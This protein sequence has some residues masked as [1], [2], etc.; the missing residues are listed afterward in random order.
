[1]DYFRREQYLDLMGIKTWQSKNV[2]YGDV[3]TEIVESESLT[4]SGE[5]EVPANVLQQQDDSAASL[6]EA[7]K[8]SFISNSAEDNSL[9]VTT[10]IAQISPETGWSELSTLVSSCTKCELCKTRTNTVF[11][12]GSDVADLMVVAEAPGAEE[13]AQGIPFMGR[14]GKLLDNMLLAIGLNRQVVFVSNVLKCQ[15][16]ENRDPHPEEVVNCMP[17]LQQQIKLLKP[18][19]ILA[20]GTVAA[21]NLLNLQTP[22][23]NMRGQ[24]YEF[25]DEAIPVVVTYHPAYLMRSPREK[26]KAWDDLKLVRF[27]LSDP[28]TNH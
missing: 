24:M 5:I 10:D 26:A 22:I 20:L 3:Q 7:E 15:P 27:V 18:K 13:N 9:S 16:P 4:I 19:V 25:G 1:M 8:A 17:Y 23:S 21:Q 12:A 28:D 2:D 6:V 14:A 11:G